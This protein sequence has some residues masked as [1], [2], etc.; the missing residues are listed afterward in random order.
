MSVGYAVGKADVDARIGALALGL[1][2][3]FDSIKNFKI[4]LDAQTDPMLTNMGYVSGEIATLRSATA[5]LAKLA[6]IYEG[7]QTQSPVYDFRSF[8]KLLTGVS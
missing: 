2:T 1:R 8:A 5:D 7:T 3:D 4:W 6:A